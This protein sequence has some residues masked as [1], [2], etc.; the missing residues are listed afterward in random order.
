M[1]SVKQRIDTVSSFQR[2]KAAILGSDLEIQ[3][4]EIMTLIGTSKWKW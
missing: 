2:V 1:S 3:L 4:S